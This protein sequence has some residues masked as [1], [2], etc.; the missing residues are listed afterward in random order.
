MDA[1]RGVH[2]GGVS[3]GGRDRRRGKP[4]RIRPRS[5]SWHFLNINSGSQE[6]QT[7][8]RTGRSEG[9][10]V[11]SSPPL[12][13]GSYRALAATANTFGRECFMDELAAAAGRDPLEFRLAH[14]EPGRLRDV[15]EE[16]AQP[17]RLVLP[18]EAIGAGRRRG[19]CVQHGQGLIR[20]RLRR[21]R[22]RP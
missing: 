1:G 16:A 2:L 21:G 17:F 8:Y 5:T 9:R 3:P 15:L 4:R 19:P 14:L 13:H 12:R 10:F 11:E 18:V 20:G 22:G 6:V 7:P